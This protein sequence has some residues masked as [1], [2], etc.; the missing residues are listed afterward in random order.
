MTH[1]ADRLQ[2]PLGITLVGAGEVA[3]RQHVCALHAVRRARVVLFTDA[4]EERRRGVA[5]RY[6]SVQ[7]VTRA[8]Q[9]TRRYA[10]EVAE[11]ITST[12]AHSSHALEALEKTVRVTLAP[13]V[14]EAG[15]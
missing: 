3:E 15:R 2:G 10:D 12:T 7:H 5:D 8:S 9:G 11:I 6:G 1:V 13:S 14:R 4:D